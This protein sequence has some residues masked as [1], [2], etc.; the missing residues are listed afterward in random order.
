[1]LKR[2][3]TLVLCAALTAALAP[4][5]PAQAATGEISRACRIS[6]RPA[7]TPRL[8]RCIQRVANQTLNRSERRKAA[9]FFSDPHR[10]QEIKMSDRGN[11]ERFWKRYEAF[12]ELAQAVC[13]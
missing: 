12:G 13:R 7:A 11:D 5:P 9:R 4:A 6:D 1:M 3:S 10:A 8:C 2:I